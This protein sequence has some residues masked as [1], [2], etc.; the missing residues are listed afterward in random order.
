MRDMINESKHKRS[1]FRVNHKAQV[2]QFPRME[3]QLF[4]WITGLRE[5]NK[6]VTGT[7]IKR[8]ALKIHEQISDQASNDY[9]IIK[10]FLYHNPN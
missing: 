3:E 7:M 10:F 6:V 5:S 2:G 8:E 1:R 9:K 4:A